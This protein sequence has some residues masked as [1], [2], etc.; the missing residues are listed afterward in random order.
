MIE[1]VSQLMLYVSA[2][3]AIIGSFGLLRFPDFYT[4]S[5]AGTVVSVGSFSLVILSL[6][7]STFWSVYTSKLVIVMILNMFTNPTATH[8][9]ADAAYRMGII[10]RNLSRNEIKK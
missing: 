4:R 7:I 2:A 8:A 6:L 1:A 9:I 5:H 10:P 3:L